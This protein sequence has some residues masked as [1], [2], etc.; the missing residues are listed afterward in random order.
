MSGRCARLHPGNIRCEG[1]PHAV[2]A[3]ASDI[4]ISEFIDEEAVEALRGDFAVRYEPGLARA[5]GD[6]LTAVTAVRA[7]IVR[8]VTQVDRELLDA[9]TALEVVGR[10]GVGLDNIDLDACAER[11]I[12]VFPATGANAVSVAEYVLAAMLQLWRP[13][14]GATARVAAGEWPRQELGG[15]E[16]AGSRLGLIGLGS[17]A[18]TVAERAS[19]LGMSTAAHDPYLEPHDA[20]WEQAERFEALPDLLRSSDAVSIHVPLTDSTRG[21][22]DAEALAL[23]PPHALLINTSRGGIVDEE[24]LV[25]ALRAG[26]LG[27]AALD[28]FADEPLDAAGGARFEG[29]PN[30]LLTPHIAGITEESNRR[31]SLVTAQNVS[32]ALRGEE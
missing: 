5:R 31:V 4:L 2:C 26:R 27:G 24:A 3:A 8:N 21:L 28:V 29:T 23:L 20:V 22:L 1:I 6:L 16:L 12:A 18:R 15:R 9:A 32:R 10:L 30:L 11:G 25:A 14:Y 13:V 19:A 7:L 17:V